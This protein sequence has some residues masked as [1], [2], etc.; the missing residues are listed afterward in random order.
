MIFCLWTSVH[1]FKSLNQSTKS[2]SDLSELN[3]DFV[4]RTNRVGPSEPDQQGR[5][6]RT[7]PTELDHQNWT[8]VDPELRSGGSAA[9]T[10][11]TVVMVTC[12]V[13]LRVKQICL[14]R[15]ERLNVHV[16]PEL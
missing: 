6:I 10:E 1:R 9:L 8:S 11:A 2:R 7:G 15:T 14:Q 5:T 4:G 3:V 13:N 16:P 12:R